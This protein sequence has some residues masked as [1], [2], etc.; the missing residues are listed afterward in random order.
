MRFISALFIAASVLLSGCYHQPIEQ[1][2]ILT[3]AKTARIRN[4]MSKSDVLGI[5]GAPVLSNMYQDNR[6]VYVYTI[7]PSRYRIH[8]SRFVV[9]FY[10]GRVVDISRSRV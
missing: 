2:N 3:S 10:K 5:L 6:L 9:T 4:G 7:Q 8:K 1:G